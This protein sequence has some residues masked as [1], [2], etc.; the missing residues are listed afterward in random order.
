VL[1]DAVA[2]QPVEDAEFLLAQPLVLDE[3]RRVHV[4]AA[5]ALDQRRRLERAPV[6]R[7]QDH[8]GLLVPGHFREPAAEGARL[9]L[10][11]AAERHVDVATAGIDMRQAGSVGCVARDI[12]AAFAV[13]DDPQ[14]ARPS[15]RHG[16]DVSDLF[17]PLTPGGP[18]VR[19]D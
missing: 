17:G 7:G 10:A 8:I 11:Q 6:G 15:L 4:K 2:G 16:G 19:S 13:A 18:G 9:L 1:F 12:A 3:V 14:P 5:G